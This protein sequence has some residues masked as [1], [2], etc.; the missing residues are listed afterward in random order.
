MEG[1]SGWHARLKLLLLCIFRH[2]LSSLY[3]PHSLAPPHL[4]PPLPPNLHL[5]FPYTEGWCIRLPNGGLEQPCLADV[6]ILGHL[7]W[8]RGTEL[9]VLAG[10]HRRVRVTELRL[11][12]LAGAHFKSSLPYCPSMDATDGG[13][14][15]D[16][17]VFSEQHSLRVGNY[18]TSTG[19]QL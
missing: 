19:S 8:A 6:N 17:L 1:K 15:S 12:L 3:P 4:P 10:V 16:L 2:F 13:P 9:A 7:P 11:C 14:A 5:P 18:H